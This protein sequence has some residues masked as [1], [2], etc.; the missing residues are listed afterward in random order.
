MLTAV[1]KFWE[2][3]AG[4]EGEEGVDREKTIDNIV[5]R[6]WIYLVFPVT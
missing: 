2:N 5:V 6:L 1:G 3:I 4:I